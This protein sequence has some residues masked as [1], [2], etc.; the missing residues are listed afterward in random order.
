VP[1]WFGIA[2]TP[3]NVSRIA[4]Y[5]A[6]WAPWFGLPSGDATRDISRA[7]ALERIADGRERIHHALEE[8]GRTPSTF[9]IRVTPEPAMGT[10]GRFHL[11][12]TLAGAEDYL[13]AGATILEFAPGLFSAGRE[14]LSTT[15]DQIAT[16]RGQTL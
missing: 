7:T 6:G 10:D 12:A 15:L 8:R 9:A 14:G 11:G 16:W 5:G 13:S 2:P 3:A 4:Q 1:I